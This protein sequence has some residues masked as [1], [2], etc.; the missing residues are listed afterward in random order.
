MNTML[1]FTLAIVPW[2]L[3][4]YLLFSVNSDEVTGRTWVREY[5]CRAVSG[6]WQ[7]GTTSVFWGSG[8]SQKRSRRQLE[9]KHPKGEIYI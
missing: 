6:V 3:K 5:A 8:L 9:D 2:Y 7:S 4:L 1:T